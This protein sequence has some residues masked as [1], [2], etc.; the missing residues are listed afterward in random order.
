MNKGIRRAEKWFNRGLWLIALIFAGFLIELGGLVVAD[1]PKAEKNYTIEMF[2]DSTQYHTTEENMLS[3]QKLI[4]VVY[5]NK[6]KL[7]TERQTVQE[8]KAKKEESFQR[9]VETR[10]AT[11][12]D[13]NNPEVVHR[14]H[15][16]DSYEDKFKKIDEKIVPIDKKI[17]EL[18][19]K[20]SVLSDEKSLIY[21]EASRLFYAAVQAQAL[22]IFLYRLLL[23][24]PLLSASAWLL[25]KKRKEKYWPF[26]WGFSLFSAFTFFVELV[27]Y[28]PSYGGYVRYVVGLI[29]T[30]FAGHIAIKALNKYL[31]DLQK[32]ESLP[33][34]ERKIELSYDNILL[35]LSQKMCPACERGVDLDDLSKNY[36]P[37]CGF[38]LFI[39]CM[40][41]QTRKS[42]FDPFCFSCGK[43]A[44]KISIHPKIYD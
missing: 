13:A 37:H 21:N 25:Y 5:Q 19:N 26:I 17:Q 39:N 12:K 31:E 28:L 10:A 15:D 20:L 32:Q 30:F 4:E 18:E 35:K 34:K 24:L 8:T 40:Q 41:C 29:L 23:V 7:L 33:A 27:P 22:R 11:Q 44:E 16:L 3:I 9:W 42:N 2:L 38:L 43:H 14:A 6:Q 1:L 36:C